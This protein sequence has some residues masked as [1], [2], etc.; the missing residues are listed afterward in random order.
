MTLRPRVNIFSPDLNKPVQFCV[1]EFKFSSSSAVRSLSEFF[2][3]EKLRGE[4]IIRVGREWRKD[5]LR[6]KSNSDLHKLWFV[7]LKE[8]NML[9]TMEEA[10]KDK[11]APMPN[12]ERMDKVELSMEHLEEV[13]RERNRA[14]WQLEVGVSGERERVYRKDC[15][16]RMIP[17]KPVEHAVP[18]WMNRSYRNKLKF[19]FQNSG[20]E[21]VNDFKARL[22][23]RETW[24][25]QKQELLQMRSAARVLRRYPNCD[26]EALQEKFPMVKLDRLLRWKK[27][28]GET[29][30]D[31]DV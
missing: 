8:R 14:Y 13:V 27:I 21:D 1:Q 23:E 31:R 10:F 18:I 11:M 20:R 30:C 2:E 22:T 26:L 9:L 4:K 28:I 16:G 7:L 17:Y 3:D 25:E 5:E 24:T 6:L 29:P 19:R 15:F 12:P